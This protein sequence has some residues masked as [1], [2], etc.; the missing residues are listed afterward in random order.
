[1]R[2]LIIFLIVMI[3]EYVLIPFAK[4]IAIKMSFVDVPTQR[5]THEYPIPLSGGISIFIGFVLGYVIF[6]RHFN[7]KCLSIAAAALLILIIGL[8]DDWYKSKG[9]EFSALIRL[10]V[11]IFAAIIVILSG[12]SF[13]GFTNPFTKGYIL[14]PVWL[15]LFFSITWIVGVTTVINWSDGL[16]GL[17]GGIS[18][19]SAST[20]FIVALTKGRTYSAIMAIMLVGVILGFLKY[21][22][23]PAQIYMGDSGANFLGFL[24]GVI[25]LDGALKQATVISIFIP[26]LAL[27]VPIFDNIFVVIK[28]YVQGKPIY[29]ADN[30]QIHYRLQLNGLNQ[31]QVVSYI[32]L[33]S[34]CLSLFSIIILLLK[35]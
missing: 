9:K 19:I 18:A 34:T 25:A 33:V 27:G 1:M 24:L 28:R 15:Q 31:K 6:I 14:L 22:R 29:Q 16:D 8:V 12:T 7:T 23:H 2:Y 4:N 10:V 20:L 21:N 3:I 13:H 35:V 32:L 5:K 17:A 11:Q 26:I 30:S